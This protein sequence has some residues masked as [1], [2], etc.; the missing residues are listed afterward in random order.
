ME[1]RI[2]EVTEETIHTTVKSTVMG[3][4]GKP[5][6]DGQGRE[7][8]ESKPAIIR[9]QAVRYTLKDDTNPILREHGQLFSLPLS[10]ADGD[11]LSSIRA[12]AEA[13]IKALHGL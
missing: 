2:R 8:I 7:V 11:T 6:L 1:Y 13:A 10:L 4:D 12:K 3:S 5:V 9:R